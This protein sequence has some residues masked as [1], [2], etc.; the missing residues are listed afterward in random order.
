MSVA[1]QIIALLLLA[2]GV[3]FIV[4]AAIGV[5]RFP[6][7][8]QR[9]HAST[10]AGTLGAVLVLAGAMVALNADAV[11][12]A[13][14]AI[15][16]M[17][18]TVPV[19]AHLLGRAAYVSGASLRLVMGRD[20]LFGV[21]QRQSMPLE[22]RTEF[23]AY[24]PP[25]VSRDQGIATQ[26]EIAPLS[27]VR[28]GLIAPHVSM[29]LTRALKIRS[30]NKVPLKVI[31][32][33]DTTYVEATGDVQH[34]RAMVRANLQTAIE[35]MEA[36]LPKRR[37]FFT[38]AYEEG[39]PT[40]LIPALDPNSLLVLPNDGWCHHGADL[41]T[42]YAT[43]RPEGLLRLSDHH[44]GSVLYVGRKPMP[45]SPLILVEDDGTDAIAKGLEW[46]LANRI[47]KDERLQVINRQGTDRRLVFESLATRYEKTL[48]DET[49]TI[50]RDERLPDRLA[51][52]DGLIT[53]ALPRPKRVDW[54]GLFWHDSIAPGW[55]GDVLVVPSE[56]KG[57]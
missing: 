14:A 55:T 47:W 49:I 39:E 7:A 18:L 3:G 22:Q 20:A 38:L 6:D 12:V 30:A 50:T 19:A 46:A 34:A 43:G 35:E 32:V 44:A 57:R 28:L 56:E 27:E 54:Y 36:L 16:F 21:L 17:L 53:T 11:P 5:L 1:T 48:M 24:A 51:N 29:P 42:P 31:A 10:K 4:A 25:P 13:S 2:L 41:A 9:M 23:V 52:A 26:P 37:S 40:Q 45:A 33:V 15:V 8:L